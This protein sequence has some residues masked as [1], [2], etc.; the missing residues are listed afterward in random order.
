M[1]FLHRFFIESE[2]FDKE[3]PVISGS[4]VNHISKVLRLRPG[5]LI[6]I[7]DG[8]GRAAVASIDTINKKDI[9][10]KFIEEFTPKGEPLL[11]VTL[12]QG[13]SKGE[14]M[15]LIVQ[16]A[17][18]LGVSKVIPMICHRSVVRLEGNKSESRQERWQR[19]AMEA[20]KQC[21]RAKIPKVSLPQSMAGVLEGI[22]E[23]TMA[24]MPW[25]GENKNTLEHVL[26]GNKTDNLYIFIGP[27]G[28]FEPFE[29]EQAVSK[30]ISTVTL[31]SRIL[32]TETAGLVC[33]SVVMFRWG[34]LK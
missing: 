28:G 30:G 20:A 14:K 9:S 2:Q 24:I 3:K 29:V 18:E 21:R 7:L 15:D 16:K 31:G 27:E 25:E 8:N 4:D 22:P 10:L 34:D 32:R 11:K 1:R 33:M 13:L 19:V 12:V 23:G 26:S 6:E 5:D 17:T